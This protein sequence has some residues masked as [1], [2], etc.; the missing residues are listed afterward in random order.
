MGDSNRKEELKYDKLKE[1]HSKEDGATLFLDRNISDRK[2]LE[3]CAIGEI[4][5]LAKIRRV[6]ERLDDRGFAFKTRYLGGR[7]ILWGFESVVEREGFTRSRFFWEDAFVSMKKWSETMDTQSILVWANISGIPLNFWNSMFFQKMGNFL[8]EFIQMDRDTEHMIRMDRGRILVLIGKKFHPP[9]KVKVV[10]GF[11]SFTVEIEVD[12]KPVDH[13]WMVENL[14]M[15]D[16]LRPE[17]MEF[18]ERE[19]GMEVRR[20]GDRG[21]VEIADVRDK[22]GFNVSGS[23]NPLNLKFKKGGSSRSKDKGKRPYVRIPKIH[24]SHP[25]GTF[26]KLDLAKK[27]HVSCRAESVFSSSESDCEEGQIRDFGRFKGS[28]QN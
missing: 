27:K 16:E 20:R 22:G 3:T 15:N 9:T 1:V 18:T 25:S 11:R 24:T 17:T 14:G 12:S 23:D 6:K 2:W 28:V 19:E 5:N 26:G 8:G 4:K 7:S 13:I 10:D 21:Q